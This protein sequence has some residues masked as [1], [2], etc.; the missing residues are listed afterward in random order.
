MFFVFGIQ[1]TA[2]EVKQKIIMSFQLNSPAPANPAIPTVPSTSSLPNTAENDSSSSSSIAILSPPLSP[3]PTLA[4][5]QQNDKEK[6]DFKQLVTNNK[7]EHKKPIIPKEAS[8]TV[9][10]KDY[11]TQPDSDYKIS[12]RVKPATTKSNVDKGYTKFITNCYNSYNKDRTK[13]FE[14]ER[15]ILALYQFLPLL[16]NPS[17][18]IVKQ[19]GMFDNTRHDLEMAKRKDRLLRSI[20]PIS[21]RSSRYDDFSSDGGPNKSD[22]ALN[23]NT[24]TNSKLLMQELQGVQYPGDDQVL[25]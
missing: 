24:N 25:L 22:T 14:Q 19:S 1:L 7:L 12:K 4:T 17:I 23:S 18:V 21:V 9:V 13:Y 16:E 15:E 20:P 10:E 3:Y 5:T 11:Q 6:I 8:K 2:T